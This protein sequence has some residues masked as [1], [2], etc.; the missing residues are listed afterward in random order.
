[1][2]TLLLYY[3]IAFISVIFMALASK[4]KS[5]NPN[6]SKKINIFFILSL[7]IPFIFLA[8]RDISV[9]VDYKSY[10][11]LYFRFLNGYVTKVDLEW[12][13]VGYATLIKIFCFIFGKYYFVFFGTIGFLTLLYFWKTIYNESEKPWM[14]LF[15]LFM[16]FF[17]CQMFNQARQMFAI[18]IAFYAYKFIRKKELKKYIIAILFATSIHNSAIVML[19]FYWLSDI[20]IKKGKSYMY[21]ILMIATYFSYSFVESILL[22]TSYGQIYL[23]DSYWNRAVKSSIYNTVV[24]IIMFVF[25]FYAS[26]GKKHS[27][28]STRVLLNLCYFCILFQILTIKSMFFGR[29]TTYFFT[30]FILLLPNTLKN[31]KAT[32][33]QTPLIYFAIILVGMAYF[34][35]YFVTHAE[36][37]GVEIYKF[38]S[39]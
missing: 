1:M 12:I 15:F 6:D 9:G 36:E 13:G 18:S 29:V 11:E 21:I 28:K 38:L 8:F 30:Y 3:F 17:Y 24:R 22:K 37:S 20:D 26:A 10:I 7:I 19:P 27:D 4:N 31:I 35:V 5:D 34:Y 39:S 33:Q 16:F 14:S 23:A 25:C 2:K 32:K